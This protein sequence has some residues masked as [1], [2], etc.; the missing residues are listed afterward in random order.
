M[1][2][3][4]YLAVHQNEGVVFDD[5]AALNAD[6]M[7]DHY[8]AELMDFYT[9]PG[10]EFIGLVQQEVRAGPVL[11]ASNEEHT[12][13]GYKDKYV[14]VWGCFGKDN[15]KTI[16]KHI[17]GGKLV[18]LIETAGYGAEYYIL[19]PGKLEVKTAKSIKF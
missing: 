3:P 15:A 7:K 1:S 5:L 9:P 17:I 4:T 11:F 13:E 8:I 16:A 6:L 18:L 2:D 10:P 14:N 19:T 12:F